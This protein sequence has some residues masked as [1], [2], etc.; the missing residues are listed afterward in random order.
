VSVWY[1]DTSAATKLIVDEPESEILANQII[2]QKATLASSWLLETELRR[3]ATRP[4]N[5][6]TQDDV[7]ELLA[8]IA[9]APITEAIF[10][11]AGRISSLPNRFLRSLDAIHLGAALRVG[12]D[13]ILTYDT[14]LADHAIFYGIP[15]ISPA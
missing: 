6:A 1:L 14:N 3:F 15:T 9:I 5:T 4:D 13:A 12:A 2:S 7:D 8:T 10:A 11:Q